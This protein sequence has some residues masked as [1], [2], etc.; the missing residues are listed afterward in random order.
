MTDTEPEL[1]TDGLRFDIDMFEAGFTPTPAQLQRLHDACDEIDRLRIAAQLPLR[2]RTPIGETIPFV[3]PYPVHNLLRIVQFEYTSWEGEHEMRTV[4]PV[5]IWFGSTSWHPTL[6]WLLSGYDVDRGVNRDFAV[7]KITGWA[8]HHPGR[9]TDAPVS[10]TVHALDDCTS[11]PQRA[12]E[13]I[14]SV[15]S[16]SQ[17]VTCRCGQEVPFIFTRRVKYDAYQDLRRQ[18][19][20]AFEAHASETMAADV[21]VPLTV[22][23]ALLSPEVRSYEPTRKDPGRVAGNDDDSWFSWSD[24]PRRPRQWRLRRRKG[25][26][27]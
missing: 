6:Q 15:Y 13:P 5:R 11:T 4:V 1:N 26:E 2:G 7:D 8:A 27:S 14:G 20:D 23:P 25:G 22:D 10:A 17:S 19:M 12:D 16:A 21:P 9:N 24:A 18:A 3:V